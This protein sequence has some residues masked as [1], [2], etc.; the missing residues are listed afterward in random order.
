[1]KRLQFALATVLAIAS[2]PVFS[3][4]TWSTDAFLQQVRNNHPFAKQ[5]TL[6]DAEA[7][8]TLLAARGGFD[9]KV[10]GDWERKSFDGKNYFNLAEGGVKLPSWYGIERRFLEPREQVA[11]GWP[12]R[13]RRFGDAAARIDD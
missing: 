4:K 6:L 8:A 7:E 2:L 9:P 10:Y 5:A 13:A 12:S 11:E 1:M 3:Q